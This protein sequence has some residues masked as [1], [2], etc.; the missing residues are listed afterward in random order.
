MWRPSCPPEGIGFYGSS[1]RTVVRSGVSNGPAV[2]AS[3]V[4]LG[5][6]VGGGV[7]LP[8]RHDTCRIASRRASAVHRTG[9]S[10]SNRETSVRA[11]PL[12]VSW[13][14][15]CGGSQLEACQTEP[16]CQAEPSAW[17][18]CDD[19]SHLM[20]RPTEVAAG[21]LPVPYGK[22]CLLLLTEREVT[23]GI[24]RGRWW[25]RRQA[26][27]KRSTGSLDAPAPWSS[28]RDDEQDA[29][30]RFMRKAASGDR[31]APGMLRHRSHLC[32]WR[33]GD[34]TIPS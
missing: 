23:A 27:L 20:R 8:D 12:V 24:R 10:S 13:C 21:L 33:T 26:E 16:E 2:R 30:R 22:G 32:Y 17:W 6:H 9:R 15:S 34:R 4:A 3:A 18:G 14:H 1:Q 19:G 7:G 25:K 5:A 31:R 28:L 11:S 29:R